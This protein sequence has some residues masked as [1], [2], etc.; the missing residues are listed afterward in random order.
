M[1]LREYL[2]MSVEGSNILHPGT[3]SSSAE[4]TLSAEYT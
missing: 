1:Y 4:E 3:A 2:F